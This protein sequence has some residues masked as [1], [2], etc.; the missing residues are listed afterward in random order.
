MVLITDVKSRL[1]YAM[2]GVLKEPK[3][4]SAYSGLLPVLWLKQFPPSILFT[5]DTHL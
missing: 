2:V 3:R 1:G 4:P 5:G